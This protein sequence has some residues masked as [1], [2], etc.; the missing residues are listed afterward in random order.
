MYQKC[1][2]CEGRGMISPPTG[3][4]TLAVC[5]VCNGAKIINEL[6]GLPP[7]LKDVNNGIDKDEILNTL[8]KEKEENFTDVMRDYRR[9][10]Q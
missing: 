8:Y 10:M 5:T 1:P 3:T 7:S 4:S 9:R 2:I 6:T